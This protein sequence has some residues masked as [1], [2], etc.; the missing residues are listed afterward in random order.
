MMLNVP[1]TAV[2]GSRSTRR[3]VERQL[4]LREGQMI[5]ID[6]PVQGMEARGFDQKQ[7]AAAKV[8]LQRIIVFYDEL[9]DTF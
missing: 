6:H 7:I 5:M 2:R 4:Y 3:R 1:L 9:M 8:E